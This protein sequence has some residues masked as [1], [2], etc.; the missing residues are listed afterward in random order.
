MPVLD[1]SGGLVGWMLVLHDVTEEHELQRLRE[2]LSSMI[3]HDLRS[4]LVAILDSYELVG[5][6]LPPQAITSVARQAIEVGQRSTRKLLNLV[7][8]LLDI[9]R[10]EYGQVPLDTQFAAMFPLVENAIEQISPLSLE[11][12][13]IIRNQITPDMPLVKVDEDQ[14]TRVLINLIDNAVKFSPLGGQ[15][16]VSARADPGLDG[17]PPQFIVC[18][19]RDSGPGIPPEYRQRIFERFIQVSDGMERR[20]GTGLGLA[21]CKL[22]IEAHG[23]S[24]W[25]ENPSEG[26]GSQFNFTLPIA[27]LP[28]P[29]L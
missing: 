28:P 17:A 20:R 8:S 23:G 10:F 5:E 25:V 13:V 19:I 27:L 16:I 4:P 1:E 14:M 2:D 18:S 26:K 7:N 22:A 9:S 29:E 24:I 3:I 21:F 6:S 15:V 11:Q 12:S